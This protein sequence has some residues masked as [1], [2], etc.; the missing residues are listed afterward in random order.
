MSGGSMGG[1]VAGSLR[2]RIIIEQRLGNR[3]GL[4]G[5]TGRYAYAG[6]AW[7]SVTPL[8]PGPL[9]QGDTVSAMPRWQVT[10]RKREEIDPRIRL[11]WRGKYL[12]VRSVISDPREPGYMILTTEELR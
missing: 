6:A 7:A 4:A 5:A 11:T 10:M 8:M 9:T 2:D 3:D 12:A 1:E